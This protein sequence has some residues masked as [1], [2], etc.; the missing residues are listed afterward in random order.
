M[1][2][3]SREKVWSGDTNCDICLRK[4][5]GKLY[6][7]RVSR[8]GSWATMCEMCFLSSKASL[9]EGRGQEYSERGTLGRFVKTAG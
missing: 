1:K 7:A 8:S 6:D 9:G 5:R 4:I 3:P 2:P